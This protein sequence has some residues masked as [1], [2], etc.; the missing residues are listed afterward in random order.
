MLAEINSALEA[1]ITGLP[2]WQKAITCA[3]EGIKRISAAPLLG[4]NQGNSQ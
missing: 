2:R 1:N 3:V 4:T